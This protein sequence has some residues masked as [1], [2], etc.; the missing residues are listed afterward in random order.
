MHNYSDGRPR[1]A[2]RTAHKIVDETS[3]A[4][5]LDNTERSGLRASHSL[6][7]KFSGQSAGYRTI[8]AALIRYARE[9]PAVISQRWTQ[10]GEMLKVQRAN[11]AVELTRG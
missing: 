8:A 3:A 5:I 6:M 1:C 4:P 2:N 10:A 7:C 9:A 11:E